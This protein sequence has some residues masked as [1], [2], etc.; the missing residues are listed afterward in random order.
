MLALSIVEGR[1]ANDSSGGRA[2]KIT[3]VVVAQALRRDQ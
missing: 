1:L 2:I 3:T